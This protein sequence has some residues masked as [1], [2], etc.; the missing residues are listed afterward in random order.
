MA[1]PQPSLIRLCTFKGM[2]NLPV[3][4]AMHRGFFKSAGVDV[5][6]SFTTGS[7][8]QL[9]G[10]ATGEFDLIQT[11]PDNVINFLQNPDS[12]GVA[13]DLAPK[14][15]MVLGGSN[16]PLSVYTAPGIATTKDLHAQVVG[17]DNPD[18]GFALVLYDLLA[19]L[20][21]L[22]DRDYTV[23]VAGSTNI[24]VAALARGEISATVLYPPF[25][26]VAEASGCRRVASS[27]DHYPAYA[28]L[29]TAATHGWISAHKDLLER[30]IA[31]ILGALQFIFE[32]SH[33]GDLLSF[34]ESQ[35]DLGIDQASSRA[36]LS[37]FVDPMSGFGQFAALDDGGLDQV[38]VL[39][40]KYRP[41]AW[42][43]PALDSCRDL[44]W[45]DRALRAL[46]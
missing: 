14:L 15:T 30:Y 32:A 44:T 8:P 2:Q 37:A 5:H 41:S 28:S 23:T 36:A 25:N 24:R 34:M 35:P 9:H 4:V 20:S 1:A 6:L 27:V 39:R 22:P 38:M 33:T 11:A 18:S 42:P 16:G 10:L 12:F 40:A 21:L 17:V 29:A 19:T 7:K 3:L 26:T 43:M 31:A 45:Y 46:N 13:R